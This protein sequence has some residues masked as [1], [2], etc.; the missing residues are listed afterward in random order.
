[1]NTSL[2]PCPDSGRCRQAGS[3]CC[4][5]HRAGA[6]GPALDTKEGRA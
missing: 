3:G 1:M 4:S 5:G 2:M 6:S